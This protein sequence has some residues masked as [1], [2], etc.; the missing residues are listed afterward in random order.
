MKGYTVTADYTGTVSKIALDKVRYVA[1][2]E[3]EAIEPVIVETPEA[4]VTFQW[5]YVLV[6]LGVI[7]AA[8]IGIG[9]AILLK[10][11]KENED[12]EE[13]ETE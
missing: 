9:I 7:A 4:P 8:G 5:V 11:R 6:P 10:R 13:E 1:I 3:G 2:Y 12:T